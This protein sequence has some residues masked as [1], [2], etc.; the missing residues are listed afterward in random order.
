MLAWARFLLKGDIP[1]SPFPYQH[2][3]MS[4]IL[5]STLPIFTAPL[6][7]TFAAEFAVVF[8]VALGLAL[9]NY[10]SP[11]RLTSVLVSEIAHAEQIYLDAFETGL[12]STTETDILSALQFKVS[13]LREATLRDSISWVA[14]LCGL[15]QGRTLALLRCIRE[16]RA[17]ETHIEILKEAQLRTESN[18]PSSPARQVLL[19]RRPAGAISR[20]RVG[21]TLKSA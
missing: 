18:P 13:T 15:V 17:F 3:Q 10:A 5:D 21:C 6:S 12:L 7:T 11:M 19:R 20:C 16:V 4:A 2:C 9:V 8:A 1:W 14:V